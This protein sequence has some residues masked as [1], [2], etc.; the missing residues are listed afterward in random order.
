MGRVCSVD[1]DMSVCLWRPA[2]SV[3]YAHLTPFPCEGGQGSFSP[4][5]RRSCNF[6]IFLVIGGTRLV[7]CTGCE[8]DE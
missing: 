7:L 1:A 6:L 8:L 4:V 2:W 3:R 5:P